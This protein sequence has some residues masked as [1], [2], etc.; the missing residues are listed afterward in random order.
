L[1]LAFKLLKKPDA[2]YKKFADEGNVN[3]TNLKDKE[4]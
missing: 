4:L 1:A 3:F 2:N